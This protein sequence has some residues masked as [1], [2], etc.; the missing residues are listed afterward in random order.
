[1]Q[2]A[3]E[4]IDGLCAALAHQE[5]RRRIAEG[6]CNAVL[7]VRTRRKIVNSQMVRTSCIPGAHIHGPTKEHDE[8]M[9][10]R[11]AQCI[12][13]Q[14]EAPSISSLMTYRQALT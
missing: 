1:M 5:L 2:C 7:P 11:K 4:Q 9:E 10:E 8:A 14:V 3:P 12:T 6:T 13:Q